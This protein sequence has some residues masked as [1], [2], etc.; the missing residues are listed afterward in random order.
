MNNSIL[1]YVNCFT[2]NQASYI[3]DALDGFCMQETDFPFV[4][5]VVDDASTDGEQDII[6]TYLENNFDL[7]NH[8]V[9]RTEETVDYHRVFSQHKTNKNCYFDVFYLKYNHHSIKKKKNIYV[10]EWNDQAKYVAYCEGDDY[11]TDPL[12][13]QTLVSYLEKNDDCSF[14]FHAHRQVNVKTHEEEDMRPYKH[15]IDNFSMKDIILKGGM[16]SINAMC[17]R[18]NM[19]PEPPSWAKNLPVGDLPL[20]L[21]LASNGRVAYIDRVMS[22]YRLCA[23]NSWTNRMH[24]SVKMRKQHHRI[25]IKMWIG[26]NRWSHFKYF[27]PVL[28]KLFWIEKNYYGSVFLRIIHH[29]NG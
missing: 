12:K 27:F 25:I 16:I 3:K 13:L 21:L 7:N 24:D 8:T 29:N 23:D 22:C 11:W 15:D 6:K 2:F 10:K 5:G 19:R 14:V 28:K 17:Y 26:F 18:K 20:R 1:V 9:V 4:C